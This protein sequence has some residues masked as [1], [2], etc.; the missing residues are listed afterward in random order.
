[1]ALSD[2]ILSIFMPDAYNEAGNSHEHQII[3]R[4]ILRE[5]MKIYKKR[6]IFVL[7]Q[8]IKIEMGYKKLYSLFSIEEWYN[9]L[10][11]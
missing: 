9:K 10:L 7:R 5:F 6:S 11:L 1:M 2:N 8:L 3:G 4:F